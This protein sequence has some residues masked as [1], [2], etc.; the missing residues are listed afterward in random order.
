MGATAASMGRRFRRSKRLGLRF[1]VRVHGKDRFGEAF[2]EA[3]G[4]ISV[5]AHGALLALAAN[6]ERG[7]T[8]VV[9]NTATKKEQEFRVVYV[10]AARDGKWR[11]GIEFVH[12]PVEFWGV[13]FPQIR[14][15]E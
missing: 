1:P 12:G 8:I 3:T 11:V 4:V 14:P 2:R 6:V 15:N 10:G 7:Q 9:E 13:F 5:S